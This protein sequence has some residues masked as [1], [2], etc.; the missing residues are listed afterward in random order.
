VKICFAT[1]VSPNYLAYA[2]V[3]GD[4]LARHAPQADFRVLVVNRPTEQVRAAVAEAALEVT[5]AEDL[6]LPDF[7]QLAYKYDLVELNTALKPSF[8]KALFAQGYDQVIYLDPDICLFDAPAPILQA[9]DQ[10]EIVLIPHALAPAMDGLRPSDIDFLRTGTFNLGFVGLRR[11]DESLRLLDWWEDRCLAYGFNDPGFGIFVDQK[12]MDLAPAYFN[13]VHILK[14]RGCNVAY[15]NLHER[16]VQAGPQGYAVNGEPL[17]FFHF[18]GVNASAPGVLSR[19]QNRHALSKGSPLAEMVSR[20]CEQLLAAGHG[21]WTQL[22]YSFANLD[23]GTPLTPLMRRALALPGIRE[24]APFAANSALQRLLRQ[25]GVRADRK[26][27][28]A[29]TTLNFDAGDR[30]VTAVHSVLR[31]LARIIGPVRVAALVRYATF[32][33]WGGNLAAVLVKQPFELRHIDNRKAEN[34]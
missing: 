19:H 28:A 21:R 17:V 1:I 15:W 6:R 30:R 33:G 27:S 31:V 22:P 16:T 32:L 9:L 29:V 24:R 23:D 4:S 26:E 8:L 11:G 34:R 20:Y 2:R 18:S 12:W 13:S 5:Y 25:A 3:L 10:H 7:E 14:H